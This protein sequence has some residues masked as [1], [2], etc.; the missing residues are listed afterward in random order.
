MR[1]LLPHEMAPDE[2]RRLATPAITK[3]STTDRPFTLIFLPKAQPLSSFFRSIDFFLLLCEQTA[4]WKVSAA[5]TLVLFIFKSFQ[6]GE[7]HIV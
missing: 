7:K 3:E 6:M 5:I 2:Q 1:P 4:S